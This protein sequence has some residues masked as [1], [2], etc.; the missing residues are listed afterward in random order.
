MLLSH[1]GEEPSDMDCGAGHTLVGGTAAEASAPARGGTRPAG[2]PERRGTA[3]AQAAGATTA[4][5][6]AHERSVAEIAIGT[7]AT[8]VSGEVGLVVSWSTA[9]G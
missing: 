5:A 8:V 9:S 2:T 3:E 4:S 6:S 7:N 1:T